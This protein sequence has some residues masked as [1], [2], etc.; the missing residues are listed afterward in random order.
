MGYLLHIDSSSSPDTSVSR[1]VAGSFLA[2][3]PRSVVHRD[4]SVTPAPHLSAAGISARMVDRDRFTPEQAAA[5]AIQDELIGE[6]LGA[7]A[8]LFTVPMYNFSVPSVFKAWIDQVVAVGRTVSLGETGPPAAGRPAVVIS[9][10]GGGYGAGTPNHGM[11]FV[12]PTLAAIL[13]SSQCLGLD[14]R[15]ILPEMTMATVDPHLAGFRENYEASLAYAHRSA[16]AEAKNI[17]DWLASQPS[18]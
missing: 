10:R 3:W 8:Y 1:S 4:L 12:V 9:A 13:G 2:T 18:V 16:R 5:A 11:D 14:M 17:A 7:G 6:F 15:T